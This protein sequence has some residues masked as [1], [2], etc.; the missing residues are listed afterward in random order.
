V[1]LPLPRQDTRV[2]RFVAAFQLRFLRSVRRPHPDFV[3]RY[4]QLLVAA[5][6]FRNFAEFHRASR[7]NGFSRR[8]EK[9]HEWGLESVFLLL[10]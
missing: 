1:Q 7:W 2:H 6:K 10:F 3:P 5:S 9:P 8:Y 4:P